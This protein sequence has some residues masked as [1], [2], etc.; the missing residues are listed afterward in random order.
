MNRRVYFI[1]LILSIFGLMALLPQSGNAQAK[2]EI[3]PEE[4]EYTFGEQITFRASHNYVDQI[5]EVLLFIGIGDDSDLQVHPV[6]F[7]EYGNLT[8]L[9]DLREYPLDGY[10]NITYWY[11]VN[12]PKGETF[13]STEFSFDYVT[14]DSN[15]DPL[16]GNHSRYIGI[17]VTWL[18]ERKC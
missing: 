17:E 2:I 9:V 14:I 16:R 8:A 15:G 13:T 7:D 12:T 11:Q 1:F 4:P 6:S 18:L 10:A 3:T 5:D